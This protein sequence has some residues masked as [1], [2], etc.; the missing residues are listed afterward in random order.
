MELGDNDL[1]DRQREEVNKK[2]VDLL[3]REDIEH[4]QENNAHENERLSCLR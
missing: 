2:P 1:E 3:E 4:D